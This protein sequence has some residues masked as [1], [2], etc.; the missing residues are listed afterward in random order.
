MM[1]WGGERR[2][3]SI[4]WSPT[5]YITDIREVFKATVDERTMVREEERKG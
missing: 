2:G 1:E 4:E 3:S 5:G